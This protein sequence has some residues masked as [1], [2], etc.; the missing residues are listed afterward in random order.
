MPRLNQQE[1]RAGPVVAGKFGL[2]GAGALKYEIGY[3]RGLTSETANNTF[4]WL[5]EYEFFF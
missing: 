2:S 1:H 5:L 4:R 3:G